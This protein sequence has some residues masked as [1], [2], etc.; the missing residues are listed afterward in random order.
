MLTIIYEDNLP[1]IDE[2]ERVAGSLQADGRLEPDDA[3]HAAGVLRAVAKGLRGAAL[4]EH[5]SDEGFD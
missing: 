4:L 5:V 2:L 3:E 1:S